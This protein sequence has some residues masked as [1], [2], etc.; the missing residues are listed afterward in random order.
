MAF[1]RIAVIESKDENTYNI[2]HDLMRN[3]R[4]TEPMLALGERG[5]IRYETREGDWHRIL[6]SDVVSYNVC[7][8]GD[9]DIETANTRYHLT[10][11]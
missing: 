8:N 9:I 11:E 7:A 10:K 3:Q 5:L 4:C 6:T 1:Y 2:Y